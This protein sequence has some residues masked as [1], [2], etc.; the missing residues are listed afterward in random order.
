MCDAPHEQLFRGR[1]EATLYIYNES[2]EATLY[3]YNESNAF[4]LQYE[5]GTEILRNVFETMCME[6]LE[7]S[8]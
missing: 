2:N 6:K 8:Y 3:I 4:F 1:M 7:K 5:Q